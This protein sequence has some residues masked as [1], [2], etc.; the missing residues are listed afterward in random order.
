M[1]T[2]FFL[3]GID[4][5]GRCYEACREMEKIH[6]Q[7]LDLVSCATRHPDDVLYIRQ[8]VTHEL[9]WVRAKS[10]TITGS[11][12]EIRRFFDR[13]KGGGRGGGGGGD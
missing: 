1:F 12:P 4:L 10:E 3:K 8:K 2:L 7:V 5:K 13:E 9:D 11:D 6:L